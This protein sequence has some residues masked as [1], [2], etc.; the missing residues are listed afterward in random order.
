[1]SEQSIPAGPIWAFYERAMA[2]GAFLPPRTPLQARTGA[3]RTPSRKP[4]ANSTATRR[5]RSTTPG[6]L[7]D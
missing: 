6:V 3:S 5:L 1:M 7:G 4:A 2:Q